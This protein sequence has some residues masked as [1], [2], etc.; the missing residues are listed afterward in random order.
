MKF[1]RSEI[2]ET[3]HLLLDRL[4]FSSLGSSFK[5]D[6]H[7]YLANFDGPGIKLAFSSPKGLDLE[8]TL[9]YGLERTNWAGNTDHNG[10]EIRVWAKEAEVYS[11]LFLGEDTRRIKLPE[12]R[13]LVE[14]A[15]D[16]LKTELAVRREQRDA[17]EGAAEQQR[18]E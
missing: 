6:G 12:L 8:I 13:Q 14:Q 3:E 7:S 2:K 17:E 9:H 18:G 1:S 4:P 16:D 5:I 10:T 11:Q 15:L